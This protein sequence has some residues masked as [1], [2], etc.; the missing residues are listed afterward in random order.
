M[1][2]QSLRW[3]I[4]FPQLVILILS[5]LFLS[6]YLPRLATQNQIKTFEEWLISETEIIS[7]DIAEQWTGAKK[8][9]QYDRLAMK[10]ESHVSATV[11]IISPIG[12]ILGESRAPEINDL[13]IYREEIQQAISSGSGSVTNTS[14]SG[15][16]VL[17]TAAQIIVDDQLA[18]FTHLTYEMSSITD[19]ET[20]LRNTVWISFGILVALVAIPLYVFGRRSVVRLNKITRAATDIAAGNRDI[21]IVTG[22]RDEIGD[23]AHSINQLARQIDARFSDLEV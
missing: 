17:Y 3:R 16:P 10:W 15:T 6:I 11:L 21:Q 8:S 14:G 4:V 2:F 19:L 5:T 20:T 23:V 7:R 13:P 9:P 1:K 18:G 12:E 22:V